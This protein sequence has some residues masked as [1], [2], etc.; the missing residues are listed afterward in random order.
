MSN[1]SLL[2]EMLWNGKFSILSNH[3][4]AEIARI[5]SNV[6]KTSKQKGIT[7]AK[8]F[9]ESVVFVCAHRVVFWYHGISKRTDELIQ[10]LTDEAERRVHEC[11]VEGYRMGELVCCD[12]KDKEY[13]GWWKID[14]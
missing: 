14:N 7:M 11:I 1:V 2:L 10:I 13:R 5:F 8:T 3:T 6:T 12:R 9:Y 4:F